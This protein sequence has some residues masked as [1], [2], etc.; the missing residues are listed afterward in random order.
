MSTYF[1]EVD[2]GDNLGSIITHVW[3]SYQS[4][5]DK[6]QFYHYQRWSLIDF[7]ILIFLLR[8]YF[9]KVNHLFTKGYHA[10]TYCLGIHLLN[11]FIGFI[12]PL[13]DPEDEETSP[14]NKGSFLP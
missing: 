7:L 8:L 4:I 12:S 14:E 2:K 9:I 1:N 13:Q 10:V 11:S 6:I 3:R 5:N